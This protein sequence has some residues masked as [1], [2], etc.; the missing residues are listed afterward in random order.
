MSDI[1]D[2][3]LSYYRQQQYQPGWFYLLSVMING[4]RRNAGEQESHAF[5]RQMGETLAERYPLSAAQTVASLE[6]Q[7]NT[8]LAH[9]N[10]GFVDIQPY[11]TSLTLRHMA[12]PSGHALMDA[13]QWRHALGAVL[14]GLYSRWLGNQGGHPDVP[15]V[16]EETGDETTL[17]FYYQK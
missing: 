15:L 7:I 5:L 9:F 10:W 12:L 11:A 3:T 2:R 13:R 6:Q 4:M 14:L 17:T 1:T 8:V 16:F